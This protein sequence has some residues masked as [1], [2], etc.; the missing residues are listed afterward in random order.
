MTVLVRSLR[1]VFH[2][3]VTHSIIS[4][5]PTP[6]SIASRNLKNTQHHVQTILPRPTPAPSEPS[7]QRSPLDDRPKEIEPLCERGREQEGRSASDR[8]GGRSVLLRHQSQSHL[9]PLPFSFAT[10]LNGFFFYGARLI[11]ISLKTL[12]MISLADSPS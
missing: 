8:P 10:K 5:L 4:H 11:V 7:S 9:S 12:T 1:E 2:C 6:T 3:P